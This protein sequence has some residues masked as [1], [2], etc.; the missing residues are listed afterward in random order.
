[1]TSKTNYFFLARRKLQF[2]LLFG[3]WLC[4][5]FALMISYIVKYYSVRGHFIWPIVQSRV[6]Y[7]YLATFLLYPSLLLVGDLYANIH[8]YTSLTL[9]FRVVTL[10]TVGGLIMTAVVFFQ[11]AFIFG[12]TV[13]LLH[14]FI[15]YFL[16]TGWR[17]LVKWRWRNTRRKGVGL[18]GTSEM[19][20][21]VKAELAADKYSEYEFREMVCKDDGNECYPDFSLFDMVEKNGLQVLAIDPSFNF[22]N[23]QINDIFRL[24][25]MYGISIFD[26]FEFY[27]LHSGKVPVRLIDGRWLIGNPDFHGNAGN[28]YLNIKRLMD[29]FLVAVIGLCA[30]PVIM[31]A[32]MLV[33]FTSEGPV[34]FSQERLGLNKVPFQCHKFR[35]MVKDA[36]KLSGPKWSEENDPRITKIGRFMRKTRI[37]ELPQL[38]NV[39]KGEMSFIGPRPEREYFI[40]K[41]E[42]EIPYYNLRFN[43]KPGLTGWAQ[44]YTDYSG[45]EEGQF[46]KLQYELYYLRKM[47]LVMDIHILFMTLRTVFN[48]EGR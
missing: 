19:V 47:S 40:R 45:S 6:D 3:D 1:M 14:L 27:Q 23:K 43:L 2:K 13:F 16:L 11:P 12:R 30:L 41:L 29:L 20:A 38:W 36:E 4:I 31:V 7:V 37:D 21:A 22:T 26:I 15:L 24:R 39:F 9:F 28:I 48:M 44:I 33:K 10:I 8:S 17:L 5:F 35:T 42:K 34:L 46:Q 18:I 32:A 25:A